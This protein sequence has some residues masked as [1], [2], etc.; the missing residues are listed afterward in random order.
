MVIAFPSDVLARLRS[1]EASEGVPATE[2]VHQAVAVW[3]YLDGDERQRLGQTAL[4]L[5]VERLKE[6]RA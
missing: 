3:S 4:G 2:V 6:G 1:I 5:V